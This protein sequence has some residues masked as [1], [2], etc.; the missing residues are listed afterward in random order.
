MDKKSFDVNIWSDIA[1]PWCYVGEKIFKKSLETFYKMHKNIK[2]NII[3]HAYIIDPQTKID[4]EEYLEYNKRRW[5]GDGWTTHLK[6]IGKK[7]GAN[8]G[9]WKTWPNTLLCHKL[10]AEGKKIN[11]SDEILDDIFIYCYELGKNVSLENTLNEIGNK[12]GIKYW[13]NDENMKSVM[14]DEKI[15][16]KQYGISGVPFFI[17][18]NDEV[19]EGAQ[20]PEIFLQAL[21]Q[22]IN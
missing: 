2:V 13:N 16:K 22:S 6:K 19:V 5:G 20:S 14:L 10:I 11:K 21:E 18:P 9:N 3:Y 7:Y 4:G 1:C 15:G 8:F 12:Y 17:F